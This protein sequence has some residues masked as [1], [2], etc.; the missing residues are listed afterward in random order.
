MTDENEFRSRA[1]RRWATNELAW[2][3]VA[4][5]LTAIGL[6]LAVIAPLL[7]KNPAGIVMGTLM[8]LAGVALSLVVARS[9]RA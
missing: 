4:A 7:T 1:P 9:R 3:V 2:S 5:L 6:F 8:I